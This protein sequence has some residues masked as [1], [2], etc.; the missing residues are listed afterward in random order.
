VDLLNRRNAPLARLRRSAQ[1]MGGF[2]V[3]TQNPIAFAVAVASPTQ[4]RQTPADSFG[5]TSPQ[6]AIWLDQALHPD[7]PI[8]NTGQTLAFSGPFDLT[9]FT[10]ALRSV[11]GENDPL[12]LRFAQQGPTVFQQVIDCADDGLE[13]RDFSA[14]P[15]PTSSAEAWIE[16]DFWTPLTPNEFPLFRF[17]LLKLHGER[18]LWVQKYHHLIID[19]TG[20]QLIASR[21]ASAYS[22]LV[23]G[24]Q[25]PVCDGGSYRLVK[26]EEDVYLASD[27][28]R[29]DEAYWLR[30]FENVPAPL[31][32]AD[33]ALTEKSRSGRPTRLEFSLAGDNWRKLQAFSRAQ[34][35]SPFKVLCCAAWLCFSRL[36]DNSEPVFGVALA[37]RHSSNAKRSAGLF[38]KLIPFQPAIDAGK[39]IV[40]ALPAVDSRLSLDLKHQRFPTD[41]ISA[42]L[43]LRRQGRAALFDVALNYVRNNYAFDFAGGP[44]ECTNIS[45]GFALPWTIMALEYGTGGIRIVID[46]D[47]GRV[48]AD[49]G[50]AIQRS[51]Q[52][53]LL[54]IPDLAE[55]PLRRISVPFD[56][57]H[58]PGKASVRT[59]VNDSVEPL[60]TSLPDELERTVV[61]VWREIFPDE[62]IGRRTNFFDLGGDSLKA[63]FVIGECNVRFAVDLPLTVLFDHPTVSALTAAIRNARSASPSP[64]VMLKEGAL[65]RPLLLIH[66]VGGSVFCY[67][68]LAL[69]LVGG[70]PVYGI[71]ASG[72]RPD[73]EV[74]E[75][76]EGLASEYLRAAD[77]EI[78]NG[79]WHLAGWSFGGLVAFEMA[80]QLA[81]RNS[82]AASLTLMDTPAHSSFPVEG[83]DGSVAIAIAA[84]LG[85]EL[86]THDA[87]GVDVSEILARTV[88]RR[89]T[90]HV[91]EEQLERMA[92]MVRT[93][94]RFRK[95]YSP[96]F[97]RQKIVSL[98]AASDAG[99]NDQAFDWSRYGDVRVIA[100]AA[101]HQTIIRAPHVDQVAA[102]LNQV[103]AGALR[104][105]EHEAG[106]VREIVSI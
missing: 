88:G 14:D 23:R 63:V 79:P 49:E 73:G 27:E 78:G 10:S 92:S 81:A 67:K 106:N 96:R 8:Y 43:Q 66:P 104:E 72:P 77:A 99:E 51:L 93:F 100:V 80:Q 62:S 85:I 70:N 84:A 13:V 37:N 25:L 55:V 39:T 57:P 53:V 75:S 12:R 24:E 30:A 64:I 1:K 52:Q 42:G 45:S 71:Q 86:S 101:T 56:G 87:V 65:E 6:L 19:A 36:Y 97:L 94:R 7:K 44:V 50:S 74:Q 48:S 4:R 69:R 102:I 82:P 33:E 46:Y 58:A 47:S 26:E 22:A 59:A 68:E 21:V 9:S 35:S 28:Y 90:S 5:L 60:A 31:V 40:A 95:E 89:G 38:S 76:L 32:R 16:T 61:E 41:H 11:I 15:D 29:A 83:G 20:R 18:F 34:A 103:L 3:R 98:R 2:A 17:A 91:P 105:E 54:D